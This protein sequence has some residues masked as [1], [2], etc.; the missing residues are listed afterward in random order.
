MATAFQ[1]ENSSFLIGPEHIKKE[2]TE[3]DDDDEEEEQQI[4][5]DIN[6]EFRCEERRK[7][8]IRPQPAI[9]TSYSDNYTHTKDV[10]DN[11]NICDQNYQMNGKIDGNNNQECDS[12]EDEI[13]KE[14]V[15]AIYEQLEKTN[16]ILKEQMIQ[17]KSK[18]AQTQDS[19]IFN[20]RSQLKNEIGE[21][22]CQKQRYLDQNVHLRSWY[23]GAFKNRFHDQVDKRL[24]IVHES[25]KTDCDY[26][27]Q[28]KTN[29]DMSQD[30][31]SRFSS[32]KA[33]QTIRTMACKGNEKTEKL[34]NDFINH[35]KQRNLDLTR[36]LEQAKLL[37]PSF[38]LNGPDVMLVKNDDYLKLLESSKNPTNNRTKP[39][40]CDRTNKN[41]KDET[42]DSTKNSGTLGNEKTKETTNGTNGDIKRQFYTCKCGQQFSKNTLGYKAAYDSFRQ[43][44]ARCSVYMKNGAVC[45]I[46]DAPFHSIPCLKVHIRRIHPENPELLEKYRHIV[47]C[48]CGKVFDNYS[49]ECTAIKALRKHARTCSSYRSKAIFCYI[50]KEPFLEPNQLNN[51]IRMAHS[52]KSNGAIVKS[53][54]V[55]KA[56]SSNS[57]KKKKVN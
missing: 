37:H 53:S 44:V 56:S 25:I 11:Q 42:I 12:D 8:H 52:G 14:D 36:K 10:S 55:A 26:V 28:S 39:N 46:C 4:E 30:S 38:P 40:S 20:R 45:D 49:Q 22:M 6:Y 57:A 16:A 18:L 23:F 29:L 31:R 33:T 41:S 51:H 34:K 27:V 3:I 9:S 54:T 50:C 1:G 47:S 7:L 32:E 19:S 43:H 24:D 35:L 15:K 21:I 2:I 17:I 13:T 48:P 5:I